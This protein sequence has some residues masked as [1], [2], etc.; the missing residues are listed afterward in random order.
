MIDNLHE[1]GEKPDIS[2]G[3]SVHKDGENEA[4][5][6]IIKC[7]VPDRDANGR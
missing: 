7:I 6:E 5:K 4:T 3:N 1:F 2:F